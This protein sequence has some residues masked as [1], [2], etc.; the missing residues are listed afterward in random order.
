MLLLKLSWYF[1]VFSFLGWIADGI[2][3]LFTERRFHN[4]GFLASP[5]CP[6]YGGCAVVM[7][8]VLNPIRDNKLIMFA[9]STV[10]MSIMFILVGF[11][12][13]KIMGFKPWDFSND[14]FN[15][16]CYM[17]VPYALLLGITGTILVGLLIPVLDTLLTHIPLNISVAL[18][19]CILLLMLIDTIFSFIT[20]IRLRRKIKTLHEDAGL[21]E[22]GV[23][24]DKL[25]EIRE[26]YNKLFTQNV[27]RK[28]IASA[29]PE[30][31]NR[32]YVKE[33]ADKLEEVKL[34]NM[35]EYTTVYENKDEKPF[36]FGL[37]FTKLFYLFMIGSVVGT[38][39]ETIWALIAEGHFEFRVGMVYGPFI[40][41]YGGGACFLTIV[42]YKLYKLND[43]LI[44]AI[45][46]VVGA[47]FEYLCSWLQETL[48]GTVSWDYSNTPFNLNGR[49][50]LMY[51]LIW[52]FLGLVWVRYL[53]PFAA[54][55]IEKIPK[56]AGSILTTFLII[57]M[58]FNSVM[59]VAAV[60]R[61][62]QRDEGIEAQSNFELYLDKHFD[63]EKMK[64]LF[65]HM[66]A[67]ENDSEETEKDAIDKTG[68]SFSDDFATTNEYYL[69]TKYNI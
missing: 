16:G 26:N 1:I 62:G 55:L 66:Q 48:L 61:W 30:L 7:Y 6:A 57:F 8:L 21:L 56:R 67:T 17:T 42:L 9:I 51:A 60:W 12:F 38:V 69:I 50:N 20:I 41:V 39:L 18:V 4:R 47:G 10:L 31:K 25:D 29:F 37:C 53:Y 32:V 63:D 36:A 11:I 27:L 64:M 35:K 23:S 58:I 59:S 14:K 3:T 46:A 65:P 43:T 45:S 49:T 54:K 24:Q 33:I 28:R 22:K 15:I 5:F 44:Y 2:R 68:M 52:G 13:K 34:D 19:V 40:P